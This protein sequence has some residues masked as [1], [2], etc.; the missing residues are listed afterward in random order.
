MMGASQLDQ[1]GNQNISCIG[2]WAQPKSQ[3]LGVRG[4]PGNTV[5]HPPATGSRK[6]SRRVFV[7]HVD[8]VRASATSGPRR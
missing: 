8:M 1:F 6:H 5:N 4:A 7:E 2:P 3:L